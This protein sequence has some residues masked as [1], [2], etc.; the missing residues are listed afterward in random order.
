MW[1]RERRCQANVVLCLASLANTV[2]QRGTKEALPAHIK[3]PRKET[4]D[5]KEK[6]EGKTNTETR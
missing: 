6:Y 1:K 5:G 2:C 4:G 3:A